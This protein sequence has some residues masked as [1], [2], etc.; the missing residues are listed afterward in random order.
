MLIAFLLALAAPDIGKVHVLPADP[1]SYFKG[2]G[3]ALKF[4]PACRDFTLDS[5]GSDPG[6]AARVAKAETAPALAIA[7]RTLSATP[8]RSDEAVRLIE[9]AVATGDHPAAHYLL[10]NVLGTAQQVRPDYPRAVRHLSIAAE[11]GNPAAAHLLAQLLI[12]GKGTARDVPRAIRLYEAAAVNGFPDAAVALGKLYLAGRYVA[13]NELRGRAWL[14][15]AAAA[16]VTTAAQLAALAAMDSKVSN[17][18]LIPAAQPPDVKIVRYGTFDNPDIPPS[19]GFDIDFQA[20]H[21]APYDDPEPRTRLESSATSL[22]TPYLYELARRIAARD[23]E[24]GMRIYLLARARMMYDSSRCDDPVALEAL[25]AWD[26]LVGP[27]I[28]FLFVGRQPGAAIVD[29]AL[30]DEAKLPADTQPWWVCRS[31]I[32]EYTAVSAGNPGPLKLR[33]ATDWPALRKAARAKIA[34][35]ATRR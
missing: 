19:F 26:I 24:Q 12:S 35:I 21:Y 25:R 28:K 14:D 22:P 6:C 34:A 9:R 5:V 27:D 23:P 16:G 20:V 13:K 15:A 1:T 4:D 30:A 17:F 2:D 29:A 18:Q 33:P 8:Q 31:G 10:G 32:A 3:E 11:R 7:A